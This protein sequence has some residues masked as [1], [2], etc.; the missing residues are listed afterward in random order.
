MS[1]RGSSWVWGQ[2]TTLSPLLFVTGA[3]GNTVAN[4]GS[5]GGKAQ[6]RGPERPYSYGNRYGTSG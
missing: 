6:G 2:V 4:P 3:S 1:D 5:L